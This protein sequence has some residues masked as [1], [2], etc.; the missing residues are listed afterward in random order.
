L[1]LHFYIT[2][3]FLLFSFL[4]NAQDFYKHITLDSITVAATKKGF[5]VNDFI[6]LIKTDTTFAYAFMNLHICN[7]TS[8]S[9]VIYYNEKEKEIAKATISTI[10]FYEEDCRWMEKTK[11]ESSGKF[12]NRKKEYKYF[13][14]SLFD[15][16]FYTKGKVC[17]YKPSLNSVENINKLTGINKR[18]AQLK[19]LIFNPGAEIGGI[20]II[21]KRLELFDEEMVPYYDYEI[22]SK[23]WQDSIECY[24]FKAKPKQDLK[25]RDKEYIVIKSLETWFSKSSFEIVRRDYHLAN[26]TALFDFDVNIKVNLKKVQ[27]HLVP[28]E[29]E[30]DGFW[31][32][33]F[34]KIERA[35]YKVRF[36]EFD[37]GVF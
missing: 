30:Y 14:S 1:K 9:Q 28:Y 16:T 33:A 18:R 7:Y 32:V 35:K 20:P 15:K 23:I 22:N 5:S 13:T 29:I 26:K 6:E 25:N 19:T 17:N 21:K 34:N 2:I 8:Q 10:Q 37:F 24:V 12:Y 11:N 36:S 27:Q 3:P 31:N 4:G